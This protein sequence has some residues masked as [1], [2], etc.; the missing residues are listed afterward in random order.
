M[1]STT[2]KTILSIRVFDPVVY[3]VDQELT[4]NKKG[5]R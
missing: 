4:P 3:E 1:S 2:D 5:G